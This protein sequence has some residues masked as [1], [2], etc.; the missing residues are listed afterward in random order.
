MRRNLKFFKFQPNYHAHDCICRMSVERF[1]FAS[2]S[3]LYNIMFTLSSS[4]IFVNQVRG[5]VANL[6]FSNHITRGPLN[7]SYVQS[8]SLFLFES[9]TYFNHILSSDFKSSLTTKKF[10]KHSSEIV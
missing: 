4:F 2:S 6:L 7:T 1:L 10:T 3:L 9:K 5:T 8:K